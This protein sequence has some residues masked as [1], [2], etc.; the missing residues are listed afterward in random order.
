MSLARTNRRHDV[1]E[2]LKPVVDIFAPIFFVYVGA[3]ADVRLLDPFA[4]GNRPGLLLGLGL[5]VI[6]FL[7]KFLAGFCAWGR[8]RRAF[9]GAGMVPRGEVGLIFSSIGLQTGAL[10]QSIFIAVLLAVFLTTFVT[11]PLLKKLSVG[12]TRQS[13]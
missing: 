3:Q 4:A 10:P 9:V 7:G 6:G 5:T 13:P 1:D 12:E 8:V 2:A 11:P